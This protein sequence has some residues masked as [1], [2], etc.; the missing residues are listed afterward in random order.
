MHRSGKW[1]AYTKERDLGRQMSQW[2]WA[3][4]YENHVT[5]LYTLRAY[6]RGKMHRQNPPAP[7]RDFNRTMEETGSNERITWLME[8]HNRILAEK[9]AKE[10][11]L[12]EEAPQ[13]TSDTVTVPPPPLSEPCH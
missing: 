1:D 5:G 10:Y 4:S 2:W 9:T 3:T 12:Q 13:S 11:V 8:E 6:L 7:I